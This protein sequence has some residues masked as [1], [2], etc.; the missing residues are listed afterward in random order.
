[1]GQHRDYFKKE[2]EKIGEVLARVLASLIDPS[3]IKRRES[4]INNALKTLKAELDIDLETLLANDDD[5]VITG[6]EA[7]HFSP[8]NIKAFADVLYH[9]QASEDKRQGKKYCGRKPW[10]YTG[11]SL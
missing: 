6:I 2:I 11:I 4:S 3:S 1:M 7:K 9:L 5:A 10:H 8:G